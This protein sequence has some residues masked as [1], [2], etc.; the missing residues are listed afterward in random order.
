MAAENTLQRFE[1]ALRELEAGRYEL[2]LYVSGASASSE[3]AIRNARE[4]CDRHLG[5]RHELTIVDINQ[6]PDLLRG[7]RVLATPTL[8]REHP[9]PE[10]MLVG[11][12]S[13]RDRVLLA[14]EVRAVTPLDA[15]SA[16]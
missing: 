10:R 4:I 6:E 3:R 8:F 15:G 16:Q 12:L 1:A 5:G 11:D 9:A 13:D 14:L 2:T 7:G